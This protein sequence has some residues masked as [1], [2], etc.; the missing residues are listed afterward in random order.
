SNALKYLCLD[1]GLPR[2]HG[3]PT[4]RAPAVERAVVRLEEPHLNYCSSGVVVD[5]MALIGSRR[6]SKEPDGHRQGCKCRFHRGRINM[7]ARR[8]Q[9]NNTYG[10]WQA[11]S[12]PYG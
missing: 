5:G 12:A 1:V 6:G 9:R 3:G 10:M 4:I 7:K 11:E 8:A 2:P